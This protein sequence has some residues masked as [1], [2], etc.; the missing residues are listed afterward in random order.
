MSAHLKR[1]EEIFEQNF[2]GVRRGNSVFH[3]SSVST[4]VKIANL[5]IVRVLSIPTK[6]D[7]MPFIDANLPGISQK[8]LEFIS[9]G[10][11]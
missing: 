3:V 7:A 8:F 1:L 2:T 5:Y 10:N 4:L 6:A 11:K 9:R